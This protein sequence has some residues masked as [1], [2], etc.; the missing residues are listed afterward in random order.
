MCMC[1]CISMC[2]YRCKRVY[3]CLYVSCVSEQGLS[4]S[5]GATGLDTQSQVPAGASRRDRD[6]YPSHQRSDMDSSGG[7][8]GGPQDGLGRWEEETGERRRRRIRSLP[9]RQSVS[10]SVSHPSASQWHPIVFHLAFSVRL[11]PGDTR[12]GPQK[13]PRDTQARPARTGRDRT[14][15]FPDRQADRRAIR[16]TTHCR[17]EEG[18]SGLAW[19]GEA[20]SSQEHTHTLTHRHT[21]THTHAH[22]CTP[23]AGNNTTS[24]SVRHCI[25]TANHNHS[26]THPP[27]TPPSPRPSRP[28][29]SKTQST[30]EPNQLRQGLPEAGRLRQD[31]VDGGTHAR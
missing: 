9:S 16:D 3:L 20:A 10:Q 23:E 11:P 17:G 6:W 2:V 14:Q 8:T 13:G 25:P 15:V 18:H 5:K 4:P 28:W 7:K 1:M 31:R 26:L 12:R 19:V 27:P 24:L 22:T 21:H 29:A 30:C